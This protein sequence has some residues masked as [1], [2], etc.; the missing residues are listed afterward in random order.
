MSDQRLRDLLEERVADLTV[1]DLVDGAWD[2]ARAV[3]RRRAA[4]AV[5]AVAVLA[6]VGGTTVLVAGGDEPAPSPPPVVGSTAP[7]S[8]TPGPDGPGAQ[9]GGEYAGV[10]VWWAPTV[11]QEADLPLLEGTGLP[12]GIDLD[13]PKGEVPPGFTAVALFQ[14]W[15]DRPGEV[16]AIGADGASYALDVSHLDRYAERG[17]ELL[18]LSEESLSPDGQY[19]FFRQRGSL[20]VYAFGPGTW[21][22][23]ELPDAAI[24]RTRWEDGA[25]EV[26]TIG[27]EVD[28]S[29][30]S[31]AG[32][33]IRSTTKIPRAYSG[34]R[35]QDEHY[36]PLERRAGQ[37]AQ[38]L[39]LAGPVTA[40][41][42]TSYES[43]DAVA[44]TGFGEPDA[45]LAM[46]PE[47]GGGRWKR[48]CA[49]VGWLD[50]ETVLFESRHEDARVL[51]W[52]VGTSEVYRVA[53][54]RGWTP[55]EESYVASFAEPN[56]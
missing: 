48:C 16:V 19:A 29:Y 20:E 5:G 6:V 46:P 31:P 43:V 22:T 34:P 14:L 17:N 1:T 21:S 25:I 7:S 26:T 42:G 35:W 41:D 30:Y 39:Y 37:G 23:L 28:L 49:V 56:P 18:P 15:G 47:A 4:T 11:A 32:Q 51:A 55:G 3:R 52:R 12:A 33:L 38:G 2:R 24:E 9:R 53:D 44:A 13:A 54:I 45:L 40:P 36:G 10:P 27:E 50:R 8:P